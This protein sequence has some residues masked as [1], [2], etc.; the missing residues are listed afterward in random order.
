MQSGFAGLHS[1]FFRTNGNGEKENN[2]YPQ[3]YDVFELAIFFLK[4]KY[5]NKNNRNL[6]EDSVNL[7]KILGYMH[8]INYYANK[9][10]FQEYNIQA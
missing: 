8:L 6:E 5:I 4:Y 1:C 10:T 3:I 2:T 7:N 9:N